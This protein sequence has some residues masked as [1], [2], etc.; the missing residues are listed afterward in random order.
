MTQKCQKLYTAWLS[1]PRKASPSLRQIFWSIWPKI[2]KKQTIFVK[3]LAKKFAN[4]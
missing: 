3:I 4:F 2:G 1:A